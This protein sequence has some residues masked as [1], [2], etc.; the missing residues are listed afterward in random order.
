M[1][2]RQVATGLIVGV[3][4]VPF[5]ARASSA[6]TIENG[7]WQV[8]EVRVDRQATR[9][10]AYG[11]NDARLRYR[12]AHI[13]PNQV[14][15]DTP[16]HAACDRPSWKERQTAVGPLWRGSFPG[17][18]TPPE[19]PTARD[20]GLSLRDTDLVHVHDLNCSKGGF[21]PENGETPGTWFLPLADGQLAVRWHDGTVLL[22]RKLGLAERPKASF[23]CAKAGTPTEHT[24]CSSHNLAGLDRSV[25]EA[26]STARKS[27][28]EIDPETAKALSTKQATWLRVRNACDVDA[29]CLDQAMRQRIEELSAE[30][31]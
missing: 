8:T 26:Y 28:N 27:A 18:G 4:A 25:S 22:L 3:F 29:R 20:W 23:D 1:N 13:Q 15:F 24:I 12:L 19:Q 17:R 6:P 2:S 11:P 10:L 31:G 30:P 7:E 16:E 9:T 21:G 14:E 5:F